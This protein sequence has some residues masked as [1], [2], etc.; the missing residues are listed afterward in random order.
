MFWLVEG[1]L[2][3][4]AGNVWN[5]KSDPNRPFTKISSNF[6]EEIAIGIGYG[7]RFDFDYFNIR[8][9]F[10]YKIR[11]P[12]HIEGASNWSSWEDIKSQGLGNFQVA[13]NYPF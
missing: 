8:F 12:Y 1:A 9:D 6:Y 3:V 4:D 11:N 2:F 10:G 5:L 7:I 13:V